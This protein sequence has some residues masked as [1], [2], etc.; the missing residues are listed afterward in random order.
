MEFTEKKRRIY[1][2]RGGCVVG[3]PPGGWADAIILERFPKGPPGGT[4]RLSSAWGSNVKR[5]DVHRGHPYDARH[6]PAD[7]QAGSAN[8]G[9]KAP[10]SAGA[11]FTMFSS[12]S[13]SN[14]FI[15]KRAPKGPFSSHS[16]LTTGLKRFRRLLPADCLGSPDCWHPPRQ[17]N[18][19]F[20][21]G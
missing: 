21:N 20:S 9:K 7:L 2:R 8:G 5:S 12:P 1:L 4:C 14:H 13:G 3:S 15:K 6:D 18:Q 16:S 19:T 11:F 10:A 17:H